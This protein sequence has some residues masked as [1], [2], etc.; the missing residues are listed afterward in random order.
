[1]AEALGVA[2]PVDVDQRLAM[3]V[4]VGAHKTSMLQ[5]FERGRP[6]EL[7]GLLG[8]VIEMGRMTGV[9]TPVCEAI[10]GLARVRSRGRA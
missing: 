2:F 6:L 9:A 7:D 4:R 1:V 8:A 5:D 10:Y 3:A